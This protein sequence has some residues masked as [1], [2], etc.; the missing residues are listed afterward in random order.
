MQRALEKIEADGSDPET[1]ECYHFQ[2]LNPVVPEALV[3]LTLGTPAALYNG[4]LLQSHL[5]YFD[6]EQRRPGLPDGVAARVEHVS[7]DHAETVLVNT[8][9]LHPRQLLV[10]AGAFGEH[11][12]TGGVVVDPDGTSTPIQIDTGPHVTVDLGPGAQIRL[13]LE[14]KRFVHRPSYDGPWRQ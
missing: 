8:D 7:A 12:F 4:G 10:Q 14:M 9:D 5:L 2:A 1:R 3:Q 6:A 11:T 13:R